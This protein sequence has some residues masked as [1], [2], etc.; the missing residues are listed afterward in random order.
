MDQNSVVA[1]DGGVVCMQLHRGVERRIDLVRLVDVENPEKLVA[2][3]L[4]LQTCSALVVGVVNH[5]RG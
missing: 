1:G 2:V 3:T 5:G 4:M